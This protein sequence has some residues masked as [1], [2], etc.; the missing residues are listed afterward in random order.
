M[1]LLVVAAEMAPLILMVVIP[2]NAPA[3]VTFRPGE[4]KLNVPVAFPIDVLAV[5]VVL[6]LV[7]PVAVSPPLIVAPLLILAPPLKLLSPVTPSVPPKEVAP[8]PTVSVLLPVIL[9]APLSEIAPVPV[10]SVVAPVCEILPLKFAPTAVR[11]PLASNLATTV[12]PEFCSCNRS[13][14]LP[15]VAPPLI[16]ATGVVAEAAAC[17]NS[18]LSVAL[19]LRMLSK[20]LFVVVPTPMN[21]LSSYSS[22]EALI[23]LFV[24]NRAT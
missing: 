3:A 11:L 6:M 1:V 5:P 18:G 20:P 19:P 21:V 22:E 12:P 23:V 17:A 15:G 10:L 4:T 16:T 13:P 14:P 9:V 8:V 2:L 24:L 7:V